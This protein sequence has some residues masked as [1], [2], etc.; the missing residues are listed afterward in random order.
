MKKLRELKHTST[1]KQFTSLMLE[2]DDMSDS[3]QLIYFTGGLQRWAEQEVKRR[4]PQT[5]AEAIAVAESLIEFKDSKK[6]NKSGGNKGKGGGAK[7][8]DRSSSS[9]G[10]KFEKKDKV[11][12]HH[13]LRTRPSIVT[14]SYAEGRIGLGSAQVDKSLVPS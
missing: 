9:N 5:L 14:A 2:V 13:L 1:I 11:R 7:P 8:T 10:G 12:R 3:T 6:D 4:N